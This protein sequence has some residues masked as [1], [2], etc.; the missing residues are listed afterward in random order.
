M[1][2]ILKKYYGYN[3]VRID[4]R[5][6]TRSEHYNLMQLVNNYMDLTKQNRESHLGLTY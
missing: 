1:G 5:N 6:P 2:N 4:F 3:V